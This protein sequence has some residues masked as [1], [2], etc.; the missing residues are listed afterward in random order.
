VERYLKRCRDEPLDEK[1][2][3]PLGLFSEQ[4]KG[5]KRPDQRNPVIVVRG[6]CPLLALKNRKTL[7]IDDLLAFGL[8]CGGAVVG[9]YMLL[10]ALRL[11]KQTDE[12]ITRLYFGIFGLV[13]TLLSVQK[14]YEMVR[15]ALATKHPQDKVPK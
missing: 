13:L 5:Q 11:I 4:L 1:H 7:K 10:S 2:N 14:A 8:W 9:V 12:E 6:D 15:I 3:S